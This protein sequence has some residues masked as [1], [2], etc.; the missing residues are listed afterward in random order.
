MIDFIQGLGFGAVLWWLI[1]QQR[2]TNRLHKQVQHLREGNADLA[3]WVIHHDPDLY[4]LWLN[5]THPPTR[6]HRGAFLIPGR[7]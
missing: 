6:P 4:T 5:A 7:R 2:D 1:L 3:Q